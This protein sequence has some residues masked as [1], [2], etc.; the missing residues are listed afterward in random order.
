MSVQK[1][2][3]TGM[4]NNTGAALPVLATAVAFVI[5][6]LDATS[7]MSGGPFIDMVTL[8][9]NNQDNANAHDLTVTIGGVVTIVTVPKGSNLA[10]LVDNVF[11]SPTTGAVTIQVTDAGATGKL[12]VWGY[13]ARPL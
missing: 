11:Q 13:F 6:T 12:T 8:F 9:A 10:I 3:L 4:V 2:P 7:S 1:R 5:H